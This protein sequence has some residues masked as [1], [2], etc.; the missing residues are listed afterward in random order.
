MAR[1]L[2][3]P[4][5]TDEEYRVDGERLELVVHRKGA[6]PA[7]GPGMPDVPDA[8]RAG[9]LEVRRCRGG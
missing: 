3:A 1:T 4:L 5:S 6:T 2:P 7:F 9:R 8:F